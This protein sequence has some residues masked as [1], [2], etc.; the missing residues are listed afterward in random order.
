MIAKK[1]FENIEFKRGDPPQKT[2]KVGKHRTTSKTFKDYEGEE[3]TIEVDRENS[4]DLYN[5][6]VR[7]VFNKIEGDEFADVFINGEKNDF[8]VF[9]ITPFDYE[10]KSSAYGFPV[11][12]DEKHLKELKE[13]YSHWIAI[14][15]DYSRENK[16]PF[17]AVAELILFTY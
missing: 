6:R 10:F 12:K 3:Q 1:V 15:N 13:K 8:S 11:A 16:D 5:M 4:F 9:K 7:L 14:S 17:I 2:L